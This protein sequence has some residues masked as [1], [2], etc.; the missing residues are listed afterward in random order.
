MGCGV[1]TP[2]VS[3]VSTHEQIIQAVVQVIQALELVEIGENVIGG[4]NPGALLKQVNG[5]PCVLVC[6]TGQ[7]T[8]DGGTNLSDDISY[9]VVVM[10]FS[11]RP[12]EDTSDD[13]NWSLWRQVIRKAFISQRL[14]GVSSVY[15][16]RYDGGEVINPDAMEAM[17]WA[18]LVGTLAFRFIC[19][20]LRNTNP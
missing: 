10:I 14:S 7:E 5:F 2:T 19:R 11:R 9:P 20:E 8:N 6:K 18:R 1:S 16:C 17:Q 12:P 3:A 15:V 13:D 4:S